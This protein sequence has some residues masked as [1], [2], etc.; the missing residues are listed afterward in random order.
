MK[1]DCVHYFRSDSDRESGVERWAI[2]DADTGGVV[3]KGFSSKRVAKFRLYDLMIEAKHAEGKSKRQ[4]K[5]EAAR[6]RAA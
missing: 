1:L 6:E 2:I 3:E 5:A 4:A